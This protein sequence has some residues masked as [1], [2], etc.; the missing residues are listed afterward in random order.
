MKNPD[1]YYNK[2]A[3]GSSCFNRFLE[4]SLYHKGHCKNQAFRQVWVTY[5]PMLRKSFSL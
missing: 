5:L 1:H 3:A 2:K 4:I